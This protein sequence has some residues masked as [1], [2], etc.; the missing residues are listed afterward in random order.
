V[1]LKMLLLEKELDPPLREYSFL[2]PKP[3][4]NLKVAS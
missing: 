1:A 3:L 2:L 4:V